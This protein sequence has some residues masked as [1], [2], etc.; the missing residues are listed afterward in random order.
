MKLFAELPE[1]DKYLS[2]LTVC[3][4]NDEINVPEDEEIFMIIDCPPALENT[5]LAG[6]KIAEK[7]IVPIMSD[8][9]SILNISKVYSL[10]EK[11]GRARDDLRI[12]TIGFKQAG[13][14]LPTVILSGMNECGYK[15]FGDLPVNRNIAI[16]I[17]S[18]KIWETGMQM[19]KRRPYYSLFREIA[20]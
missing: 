2:N 20:E 10:A 19:D 7:I 17:A 4:A 13:A 14:T 12:V 1:N 3:N 11:C 15:I 9:F 8:V 6:M 18:G 16:N 5:T